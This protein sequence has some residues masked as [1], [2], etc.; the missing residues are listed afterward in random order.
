M[1]T[2]TFD[3]LVI[4][5][6]AGGTAAAARLCHLGYRTLLVEQRDRVG[7]RA[8]T[9][10]ITAEDGTGFTVN[11]GALVFEMGGENGRLFDDVG[12]DHGA[13][14][15]EQPLVLRIGGRD[16]PLM[17]GTTGWLVGRLAGPL[18]A[19]ARKIPKL[20]PA[21]GIDTETWLRSLHAGG[22]TKALF[23]SL[24]SALFAAEPR[25]VQAALFFDYLTKPNALGIYG[26]HP[27]GSVGPWRSLA[28]HY[29]SAGG[30]LWLESS[31]ESLTRDEAGLVSGAVIHRAATAESVTVDARVVVSNAGPLATVG[32]CGDGA[33]PDGYAE[34]IRTWSKPG[35]LVTIN[36]A[37]RT[38]MTRM[39]GLM[40]FGT[41]R[42]LSYGGNLTVMSPKMVPDG[43]HLYACACTPQPATGDFDLDAE[44]ELLKAD[45]RDN[46][47][48]F[49]GA[50]IL[51]VEVCA[52]Q[53]WPAQ[54]GIAGNGQPVTT[55]I[56]NL[57]NVGDGVYQWTGAGQSGCVETARL[58]VE[59]IQRRY[60]RDIR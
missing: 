36:F 16:I 49:E 58:V 46:F 12:A 25:D 47:P 37:S 31:V 60:P 3:A 29:Q 52:G 34:G 51:T 32:F 35:S 26:T 1:S 21:P 8:S 24:A 48:E 56:A 28:E 20:R 53:E 4:G 42:R 9:K 39:G 18:G 11:T 44:V 15:P 50:T 33:F 38:P 54:R 57:W 43:W 23:Q 14:V 40:F 2:D 59:Q 41:T 7:G 19:L 13:S 55:P 10:E 45:L 6:G 22:R 27:E 17:S 30:E 5:A